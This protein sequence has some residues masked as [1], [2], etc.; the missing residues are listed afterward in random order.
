MALSE[1]LRIELFLPHNT[2]PAYKALLA[3][4]QEEFTTTF[5]GCTVISHVE[6]QYQSEENQQTITDPIQI[7][8]VD[9]NLQPA[10]HQQDVQRHLHQ[11]YET[12]YEALEE[13][14][15][16]ISVYAVSHVTPPPFQQS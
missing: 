6:G 2:H 9:T 14:A 10:L 4:F 13:E 5:G 15:I 16:L 8:F 11:I 1:K 3:T 7:L 12:A